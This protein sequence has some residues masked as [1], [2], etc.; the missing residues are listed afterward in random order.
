MSA[1]IILATALL[2]ITLHAA[3]TVRFVDGRKPSS[4]PGPPVYV[5]F[6][7]A[8]KLDAVNAATNAALVKGTSYPLTDLSQGATLNSFISGRVFFSLG[9]PLTSATQATGYSPNFDNPNL[10]DFGTR[11]EKVEISYDPA[12]STGGANL[13]AV[14][15]F[16]MRLQL[17]TS[18]GTQQPAHLG[19]RESTPAIMNRLAQ[20]AGLK[21]ITTADATP[22]IALGN[23]GISVPGITGQVVRIV[24]PASVAPG[25]SFVYPSLLPY[26]N[27]LQNVSTV[28][29]GSDGTA[30][31]Y[32][33]T[34]AFASVKNTYGVVSVSP[35]DLVLDG[36]VNAASTTLVIPAGY[37]TDGTLYG[38][39]SVNPVNSGAPAYLV[40]VGTQSQTLDRAVADY[41]AAINFGLAGSPGTIPCCPE[42]RSAPRLR[43]RGTATI[44]T[45]SLH[46]H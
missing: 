24:S 42:Q 44:P 28:I 39:K 37:I 41:F 14:D 30:I 38:A 3:V 2:E 9:A 33:F 18:G 46:P 10:P 45:L 16:S 43:G 4:P 7:G 11:W 23:N 31:K 5:T 27:S 29:Q 35:G 6:G 22:A 20:L 15:F 21:V 8:N 26:L 12:A 25:G 34:A 19:Y 17:D 13:S 36:T 1:R 40:A 32:S